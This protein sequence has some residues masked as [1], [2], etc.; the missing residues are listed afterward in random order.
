MSA[1]SPRRRTDRPF[2]LPGALTVT[3]VAKKLSAGTA[4]ASGSAETAAG[5][6]TLSAENS[7]GPTLNTVFP[8]TLTGSPA[9]GFTITGR[10]VQSKS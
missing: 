7:S 5:A 6:V 8:L 3:L 4:G 9:L 2:P 10:Q 1:L